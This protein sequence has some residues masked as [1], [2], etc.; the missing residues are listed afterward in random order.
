MKIV[1]GSAAI[2]NGD[3][4][5][6]IGNSSTTN[7]Y[8]CGDVNTSSKF[9]SGGQDLADIFITSAQAGDIT[10]VTTGPYLT[11][12]GA[13][14][15]VEVGIDSACA[16]AWDAAVAG[17]I[18][19]VVAGTG[20]TGGGTSGSVTLNLS[21]GDGVQATAN[22]VSVDSTV[23]RTTGNQTIAGTKNFSG[24]ICVGTD[25]EHTGNPSTCF[26]FDSNQIRAHAAGGEEIFRVNATGM[27]VNEGGQPNDF[28]V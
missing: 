16:A 21:A 17:D 3:N 2:G 23:V 27:V 10:A 13:S 4:T 15:S 6:T 14:G 5:T 22:C 24:K 25:I 7:A 26:G 18:S 9:I 8:I 12:G 20:L 11:G 19:A 1:I 28:R